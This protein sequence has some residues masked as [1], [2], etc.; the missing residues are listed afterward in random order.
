MGTVCICLRVVFPASLL[1]VQ[2][3]SLENSWAY[4]P[5][6]PPP[7]DCLPSFPDSSLGES[8]LSQCPPCS[9]AAWSSWAHLER[10]ACALVRF[11]GKAHEPW[12][13]AMPVSFDLSFIL[14]AEST[15]AVSLVL[16]S[17]CSVPSCKSVLCLSSLSPDLLT[18][19]MLFNLHK[20]R[21]LSL[22]VSPEL[23]KRLE[24]KAVA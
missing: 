24:S 11:S 16:W 15:S 10:S 2:V 5:P 4:T 20:P 9:V 18:F 12:V 23:S 7:S 13:R 17:Y 22:I 8:W 14:Q 21:C 1:E 3:H 6:P 19:T